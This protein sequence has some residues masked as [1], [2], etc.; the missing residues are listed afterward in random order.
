MGVMYLEDTPLP[1]IYEEDGPSQQVGEVLFLG[2]FF[3]VLYSP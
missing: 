2:P 1:E 3:V